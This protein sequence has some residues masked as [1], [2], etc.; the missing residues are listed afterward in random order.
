MN[1][2]SPLIVRR[3]GPMAVAAPFA[4]AAPAFAEEAPPSPGGAR[5]DDTR[6][7]LT[8]WFGGLI[9]FGTLIA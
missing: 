1:R 6:G 7:F 9:F 4:F 5:V 2:L 8:A 3:S